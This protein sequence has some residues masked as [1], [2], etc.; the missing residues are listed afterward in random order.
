MLTITTQAKISKQSPYIFLEGVPEGD[1]EVV[2]V[3]QLTTRGERAPITFDD[4]AVSISPEETF[5]RDE[6]YSDDGR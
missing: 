6:I 2:I 5:R 3:L 1:Y 4:F